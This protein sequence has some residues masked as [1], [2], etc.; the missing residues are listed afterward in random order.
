MKASSDCLYLI[1]LFELCR[2]KAY[3]DPKTG[4]APYTVGWGHTGHDVTSETV[5]TQQQ[6]DAAFA[7]NVA[8]FE[9]GVSG[10]VVV[11]IEQCEFDALVS[12]AYNC[13][14]HNLQS[15]TM[16]RWLNAGADRERVAGQLMRWVSPGSNVE[17]GLRK[18]RA[19][20]R[21][22]FLGQDWRGVYRDYKP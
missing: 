5:W 6:A 11:P 14:L 4:G 10:L 22:L 13:G 18:R 3:P 1:K 20:E 7:A 21:A 19:V 17:A 16:L 15:S 2:L 12:F 9:F 8:E